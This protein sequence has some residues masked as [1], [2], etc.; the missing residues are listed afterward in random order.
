MVMKTFKE[1]IDTIDPMKVDVGKL[2]DIWVEYANFYR[3]KGDWK[4][5]N[6]ILD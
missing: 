4:T 1:A 5:A 2:S 6:Q 3:R